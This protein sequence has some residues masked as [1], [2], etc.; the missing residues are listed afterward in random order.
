MA[1]DDKLLAD[2]RADEGLD[3][4]LTGSRPGPRPR[5]R[6]RPGLAGRGAHHR[7]NREATHLR[8]G[9]LRL[10]PAR[11]P[12]GKPLVIEDATAGHHFDRS[13]G[14]P[15][16]PDGRH[17]HEHHFVGQLLGRTGGVGVAR[18]CRAEHDLGRS[19]KRA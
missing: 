17:H 8:P 4:V 15:Q 7:R 19:G 3:E 6:R 2:A 11:D 12:G 10:H 14:D 5:V 16:T 13:V 18:C 1:D 9:H